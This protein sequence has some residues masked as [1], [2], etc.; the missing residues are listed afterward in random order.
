M[1]TIEVIDMRGSTPVPMAFQIP[2]LSRAVV[3]HRNTVSHLL[4][5]GAL[6]VFGAGVRYAGQPLPTQLI[7]GASLFE[8]KLGEAQITVALDVDVCELLGAAPGGTELPRNLPPEM[9]ALAVEQVLGGDIETFETDHDLE[10]QV[11]SVKTNV[12][13]DTSRAVLAASVTFDALDGL[14]EGGVQV[15]VHAQDNDALVSGLKSTFKPKPARGLDK[16][17]VSVAY[18]GPLSYMPRSFLKDLVVGDVV[19][20]CPEWYNLSDHLNLLIK[21][22]YILPLSKGESGFVASQPEQSLSQL[23]QH[24][25]D[26]AP[27]LPTDNEPTHSVTDPKTVVTVELQRTEVAMSSLSDIQDGDI[28]DF[29]IESVDVVHICADGTPIAAGRLVQL[30][31]SFGVQV[32]KLL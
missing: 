16:L 20:V 29:D 5:E 31:D 21:N 23:R 1:G 15:Y 12:S 2:S 14:D 4:I 27:L 10:L 11:L 28:L 9:L 22:E 6:T 24:Y 13:Y 26:G 8:L 25:E 17:K 7:V 32:T 18:V 30:E 3:E 19:D